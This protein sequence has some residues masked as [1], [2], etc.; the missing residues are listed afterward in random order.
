MSI[1]IEI[2]KTASSLISSRFDFM[3]K[4]TVFMLISLTIDLFILNTGRQVF[5]QIVMTQIISVFYTFADKK[6][7][8]RERN[9]S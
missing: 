5:W 8:F 7:V 9:A 6:S 2:G 3:S 4:V 1:N